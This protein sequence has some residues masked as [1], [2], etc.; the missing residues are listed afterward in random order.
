MKNY[1]NLQVQCNKILQ[2][3]DS[4][5]IYIRTPHSIEA[6]LWTPIQSCRQS[7]QPRPCQPVVSYTID[8]GYKIKGKTQRQMVLVQNNQVNNK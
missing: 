1:T 7:E 4:I 8:H 6:K 3:R 2:T 5:Y